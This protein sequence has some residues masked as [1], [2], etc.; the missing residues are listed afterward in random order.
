MKGLLVGLVL[1]AWISTSFHR[2]EEQ[3]NLVAKVRCKKPV[4]APRA[5]W[6]MADNGLSLS[7]TVGARPVSE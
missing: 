1:G 2:V 7:Y 6:G 3:T 4:P 5:W